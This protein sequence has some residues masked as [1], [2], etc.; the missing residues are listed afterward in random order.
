MAEA[1]LPQPKRGC[2]ECGGA[3]WRPYY[4]EA[5]NGDFEKAFELCVCRRDSLLE[6]ASDLLAACEWAYV[7]FRE[8]HK[9]APDESGFGGEEKVKRYLCQAINRA[10]SAL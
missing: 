4:R 2:E 1:M 10:K 9:H 3:G 6:A 5:L 8:F 7:W